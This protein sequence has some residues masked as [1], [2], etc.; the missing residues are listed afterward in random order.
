MTECLVLGLLPGNGAKEGHDLMAAI[1]SL[2]V[3]G[4]WEEV[5]CL[6]PLLGSGPHQMPSSLW[7]W[8]CASV[9]FG[10][11]HLKR[12]GLDCMMPSLQL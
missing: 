5:S 8:V 9:L 12:T 1:I 6:G 4:N 2:Q 3:Q 11:S 7:I 10:K